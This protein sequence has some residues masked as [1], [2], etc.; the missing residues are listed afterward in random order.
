[1]Q[2]FKSLDWTP[3]LDIAR[4]VS[5]D[6]SCWAFLYSGNNSENKGQ[7]S[8][9]ALNVSK[10]IV[11]NDFDEIEKQL[12]GDSQKFSNAWFGYLG[13]GLKD[14][15]ES[16]PKDT[17]YELN[18][19]DLWLAKYNL[20]M[21]FDHSSQKIDVWANAEKYLEYIPKNVAQELNCVVKAGNIKSNMNK[22]EYL[23][24]V[25]DIQKYIA[26]GTIYQA[27][28][29]RKF[30]GKIEN[31]VRKIDIFAK[32][33][34]IS[35]S[36]YS[37]FFKINDKYILSSSPERFIKVDA[38]GSVNMKPIKGSA[39][40]KAGAIDDANAKNALQDSEKDRA[41]NLMIVDLCRNDLSR[42][43]DLGSVKVDGLFEIK[44]YAT[45]HHMVS[46]IL[47]QKRKALSSLELIKGCFPPG[48]MTG[49]PKIKAMEICTDLETLQRG[50]YS[51]ALGWFA[52]DGGVDLS[53]VIRTIV[54]DGNMFEFQVGGAIVAD[55]KAEDEWQETMIKAKAVAWSLG[56][57]L[58]RL[59]KI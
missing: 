49:A 5:D 12:G 59:E 34:E 36:E 50:V 3:P 22:Q 9:I 14:C 32:L 7:I 24:K 35:P 41:E 48:S 16:L 33:C 4:S 58:T 43:C 21:V 44:T 28:L 8:I 27:N 2:L 54:F 13:Y 57:D 26:S 29:T 30:Y 10:Q 46:T 53:V 15:L 17:A 47:G 11:A 51:G 20:I 1:M 45:V 18:F 31:D 25:I 42:S 39:C 37:A 40:R 52:G 55:S 23:S 56:I 19:P 38:Y 6:E